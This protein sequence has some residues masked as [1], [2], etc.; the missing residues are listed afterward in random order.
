MNQINTDERGIVIL[1]ADDPNATV[2]ADCGAAWDDRVSTGWTP[3]PAGRCPWEDTHLPTLPAPLRI[4][5][6]VTFTQNENGWIDITG[7]TEGWIEVARLTSTSVTIVAHLETG[8][9]SND[10]GLPV[11]IEVTIDAANLGRALTELFTRIAQLD[12]EDAT[13]FVI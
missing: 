13:F 4:A 3:T 9:T 5:T 10:D 2:C 1:D 8:W 6:D 12:A 7:S 11:E